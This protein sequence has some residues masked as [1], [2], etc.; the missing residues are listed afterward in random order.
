MGDVDGFKG[1][2]DRRKVECFTFGGMAYKVRK[3]LF[4]VATYVDVVPQI[5]TKTDKHKTYV[6]REG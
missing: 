5:H 1:V 3:R 4:R 2:G 6:R